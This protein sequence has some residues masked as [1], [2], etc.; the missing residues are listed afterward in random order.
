[1]SFFSDLLIYNFLLYAL[2]AALL[3]SLAC[4]IVGTFVVVKKIGHIAGGISHAILGG[5][6]AAVYIG[7][8]PSL[9]ALFSALIAATLIGI[10]SLRSEEQET[11]FINALWAIGMAIGVVFIHMTPGYNNHLIHFLFGNILMTTPNELYALAGLNILIL[12]SVTLFY[13]QLQAICFDSEYASLQNV[14]IHKFYFFLLGLISVT[15][16][17]LVQMVGVILVIALLTLPSA[18]SLYFFQT[19]KKVIFSSIVIGIFSSTL[20]LMTSYQL[21]TPTGATIILI[22]GLFYFLAIMLSSN[23]LTKRKSS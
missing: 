7:L 10:V 9:G 3:S 21:N 13:K 8:H 4:G 6:G 15:I 17:A 5:M 22:L 20:G 11:T 23:L 12:F 19:L 1:M 18:I 14:P 2:L 16:V